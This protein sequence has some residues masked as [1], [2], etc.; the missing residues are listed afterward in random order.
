MR[1]TLGKFFKDEN[2]DS[3]E[4]EVILKVRMLGKPVERFLIDR[5]NPLAFM[6]LPRIYHS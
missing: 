3:D 1:S 4:E 6:L 2:V 5:R